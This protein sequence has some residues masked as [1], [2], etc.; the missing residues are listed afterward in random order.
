M[1]A[2]K[3]AA[4]KQAAKDKRAAAK[5]AK[6]Q[7]TLGTETVAGDEQG[8]P[9]APSPATETGPVVPVQFIGD[10]N[11]VRTVGTIQKVG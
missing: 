2:A 10:D 7:A 11:I 1:A 9:T 5:A 3:T 6:A 8:S 4:Q